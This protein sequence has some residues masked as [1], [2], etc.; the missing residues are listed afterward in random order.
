MQ[1]Y[2]EKSSTYQQA[3]E[4]L[5]VMGELY[6]K[7]EMNSSQDI[8][9]LSDVISIDRVKSKEEVFAF[10]N[11]EQF[12]NFRKHNLEY[13]VLTP[14]CMEGPKA[15]MSDYS[16]PRH[17]WDWNKYPTFS[18]TT[19]I[20]NELEAAYPDKV[21]VFK[22]GESVRGRDIMVIKVSS[23]VD[24]TLPKAGKYFSG[25]PHGNETAGTMSVL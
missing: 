7:F 8:F 17:L 11:N 13:E 24:Q 20:L 22:I 5:E 14:P 21:K 2:S 25:A 15:V 23:D 10:A 6:F 9:N 12:E 18:G 1:S 3:L 4:Q 16:G 19:T